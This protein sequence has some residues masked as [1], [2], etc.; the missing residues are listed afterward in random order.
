MSSTPRGTNTSRGGRGGGHRGRGGGNHGQGRTNAAPRQGAT[1]EAAAASPSKRGKGGENY[2]APSNYAKNKPNFTEI[3]FDEELEFG[4]KIPKDRVDSFYAEMKDARNYRKVFV[5]DEKRK[6]TVWYDNTGKII[7]KILNLDNH[8]GRMVLSEIGTDYFPVTEK[9]LR[10]WFEKDYKPPNKN[11]TEKKQ[12]IQ[13]ERGEYNPDELIAKL[14]SLDKGDGVW[15]IH[16][17]PDWLTTDDKRNIVIF[18][19]VNENEY[20]FLAK[21]NISNKTITYEIP[22]PSQPKI[23]D[24]SRMKKM[25]KV[26]LNRLIGVINEVLGEKKVPASKQSALA[27]VDNSSI[28]PGGWG[29]SSPPSSRY[30]SFSASPYNAQPPRPAQ[31]S[32]P[33]AVAQQLFEKTSSTPVWGLT[34]K[35]PLNLESFSGQEVNFISD[36]GGNKE[37]NE[38]GQF[39]QQRPPGFGGFQQQTQQM[40]FGQQQLQHLVFVPDQQMGF[41]TVNVQ[42]E[43]GEPSALNEEAQMAEA[44]EMSL[45][46]A[47]QPA[48]MLSNHDEF[49]EFQGSDGRTIFANRDGGILDDGRP[50]SSG[51][52]RVI[53]VEKGPS[54]EMDDLKAYVMKRRRG[55]VTKDDKK[56]HYYTLLCVDIITPI[57]C[58]SRLSNV[59]KDGPTDYSDEVKELFRVISDSTKLQNHSRTN[60]IDAGHFRTL[61]CILQN[62]TFIESNGGRYQ[63]TRDYETI[64]AMQGSRTASQGVY[65]QGLFDPNVTEALFTDGR[66]I[67]VVHAGNARSN[68]PI[69][70]EAV[71]GLYALN[72]L[73]RLFPTFQYVFTAFRAPALDMDEKKAF[74]RKD[75]YS[76]YTLVEKLSSTHITFK[77]WLVIQGRTEKEVNEVLFQIFAAI[78]YA[79]EKYNFSHNDLRMRNIF[80]DTYE[81]AQTLDFIDLSIKTKHVVKIT[82]FV[83]SHIKLRHSDDPN[84]TVKINTGRIAPST[85]YTAEKS[86]NIMDIALFLIEIA[87]YRE[88][89]ECDMVLAFPRGFEFKRNSEI[90]WLFEFLMKDTLGKLMFRLGL[91]L[92]DDHSETQNNQN[93]E[94]INVTEFMKECLSTLDRED[95]SRPDYFWIEDNEKV[96]EKHFGDLGTPRGEEDIAKDAF[97]KRDWNGPDVERV[98]IDRMFEKRFGK[99]REGTLTE[100]E[101]NI[102]LKDKKN[103]AEMMAEEARNGPIHLNS[104]TSLGSLINERENFKFDSAERNLEVTTIEMTLIKLLL[105]TMYLSEWGS[106]EIE[107]KD[108][109]LKLDDTK[110]LTMVLDYTYTKGNNP[111]YNAVVAELNKRKGV[112]GNESLENFEQ[113]PDQSEAETPDDETNNTLLRWIKNEIYK[114]AGDA[115]DRAVEYAK[116]YMGESVYNSVGYLLGAIKNSLGDLATLTATLFYSLKDTISGKVKTLISETIIPSFRRVWIKYRIMNRVPKIS[117]NDPDAYDTDIDIYDPVVRDQLA[118]GTN[119][120][121]HH[122]DFLMTSEIAEISAALRE[123]LVHQFKNEKTEL[124]RHLSNYDVQ[125][126]IARDARKILKENHVKR[127]ANQNRELSYMARSLNPDEQKLWAIVIYDQDV[128]NYVRQM[129][130]IQNVGED[131]NKRY[132]LS[133]QGQALLNQ[134]YAEQEAI[135]VAAEIQSEMASIDSIF[136]ETQEDAKTNNPYMAGREAAEKNEDEK[137]L[138]ELAFLKSKYDKIKII[139]SKH[140]SVN[141]RKQHALYALEGDFTETK[142]RST[143]DAWKRW[144]IASWRDPRYNTHQREHFSPSGNTPTSGEPEKTRKSPTAAAG[145]GR[146]GSRENRGGEAANFQG[147]RRANPNAPGTQGES[148]NR[149]KRRQRGN[150]N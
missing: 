6:F 45:N 84:D 29:D 2:G 110:I 22:V 27:N 67:F 12:N 125:P 41:D 98:D 53:V 103:V 85:G 132:Q 60:F 14:T 91:A 97:K 61:A 126:D 54:K 140:E 81:E 147:E 4:N 93:Q 33:G 131:F 57:Y 62:L 99:H 130:A 90:K 138:D 71:V 143:K 137:I 135:R 28:L 136:Y 19:F 46:L 39:Q 142:I 68:I 144:L 76:T 133:N 44:T 73:K 96:Y 124:E 77:K 11:S 55:A 8:E 24:S 36:S 146:Q 70:N 89:L 59:Y 56:R 127:A 79:Q 74:K 9:E 80:I 72:N 16:F 107:V 30:G 18:R 116:Y 118:W 119:R 88:S 35:K 145:G 63:A 66:D 20:I 64:T 26:D 104:Y 114:R 3:Q 113:I 86:N 1:I 10:A 43:F 141:T 112:N 120:I 129:E 121:K 32:Q 111:I 5:D 83:Y 52:E 117:G 50:E 108:T 123:L 92:E 139:N 87:M 109:S 78:G 128:K 100:T 31:A 82:N 101:K 149:V 58:N 13:E 122:H 25:K 38:F 95:G 106:K 94:D 21:I 47:E 42:G 40:G 48:P 115:R 134:A 51:S 37:W 75:F 34:I 69:T 49:G 150:G 15:I 65:A 105:V 23:L 7:F 17:P 148:K 102:I